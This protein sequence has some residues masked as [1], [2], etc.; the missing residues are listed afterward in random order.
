MY[1]F[2]Y[3][4]QRETEFDDDDVCLRCGENHQDAYE[5][6]IDYCYDSQREAKW[7]AQDAREQDNSI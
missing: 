5:A 3:S 1:K 7:E 6:W 2:C 4:C